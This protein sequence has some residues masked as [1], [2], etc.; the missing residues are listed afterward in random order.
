MCHR[1]TLRYVTLLDA[2]IKIAGVT[3][4]ALQ[5]KRAADSQ[6][7]H[8]QR[9]ILSTNSSSALSGTLVDVKRF[10]VEHDQMMKRPDVKRF[11]DKWLTDQL[12]DW[13]GYHSRLR[14]I[15]CVEAVAE[16][17]SDAEWLAGS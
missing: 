17:K 9:Q 5:G 15:N 16:L 8:F 12:L 14:V 3:W 4:G 2:I 7:R 13:D 1:V 11:Y 10:V 6:M